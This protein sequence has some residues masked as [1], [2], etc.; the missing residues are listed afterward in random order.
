MRMTLGSAFA[1]VH[2]AIED[3]PLPGPYPGGKQTAEVQAAMCS[4]GCI[5]AIC[6]QAAESH[7]N[8]ALE[9]W[10]PI[11]MLGEYDF[12]EKNSKMPWEFSLRNLP[13]ES[14]LKTEG[15]DRENFAAKQR[16]ARNAM[17][18]FVPLF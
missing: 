7:V 3:L 2:A 6:N 11:N 14:G 16:H 4:A 8:H 17:V 13:L 9:T 10:G 15:R 18:G 1:W 12:E 5:G